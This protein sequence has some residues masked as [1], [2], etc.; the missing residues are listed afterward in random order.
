MT[1][2]LSTPQ[3]THTLVAQAMETEVGG[4]QALRI[5]GAGDDSP[6]HVAPERDLTLDVPF[7][8]L[9]AHRSLFLSHYKWLLKV[10]HGAFPGQTPALWEILDR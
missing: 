6:G 1:H 5:W 3:D 7:Y 8:P 2:V 10:S 4:L 9:Q